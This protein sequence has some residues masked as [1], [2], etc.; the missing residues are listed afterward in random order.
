M[1]LTDHSWEMNSLAHPS[2]PSV[3]RALGRDRLPLTRNLCLRL[4][5]VDITER[6]T[7]PRH[8]FIAAACDH[9]DR[10]NG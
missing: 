4:P 3:T 10:G 2:F 5:P 7:I 9:G 1:P 8:T 6:S